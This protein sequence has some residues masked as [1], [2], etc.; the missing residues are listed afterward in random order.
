MSAATKA[1][2]RTSSVKLI[3]H[4]HSPLQ[5]TIFRHDP[6]DHRT[7]ICLLP[8]GYEVPEEGREDSRTRK[9]DA[10]RAGTGCSDR[11]RRWFP[12]LTLD[13]IRDIELGQTRNTL[14]T[15]K[16][17]DEAAFTALTALTALTETKQPTQRAY[18]RLVFRL[19]ICRTTSPPTI[20]AS[21]CC[22]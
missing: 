21:P 5:D 6:R 8:A 9:Q 16:L 10:C 7:D 22:Q 19:G 11:D 20:K 15:T 3:V 17:K 14:Q 12:E 4:L 18:F 1:S 13:G 2:Q